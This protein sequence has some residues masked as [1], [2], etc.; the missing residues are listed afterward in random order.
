MYWQ[1]G[2]DGQCAM[3]GRRAA[4]LDAVGTP[5]GLLVVSN[6]MMIISID[7]RCRVCSIAVQMQREQ[8]RC[9]AWCEAVI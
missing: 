8:A 2:Y 9:T 1:S 7:D 6:S 3:G 5:A 4:A